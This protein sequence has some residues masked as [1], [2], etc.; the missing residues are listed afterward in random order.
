[1][2]Y[3]K[4]GL[5]FLHDI[6]FGSPDID[7]VNKL[8]TRRRRD[9]IVDEGGWEESHKESNYRGHFLDESLRE[10]LLE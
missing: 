4:L 7:A 6:G 3:S 10:A 8:L 2:L 5:R 9:I 1:L